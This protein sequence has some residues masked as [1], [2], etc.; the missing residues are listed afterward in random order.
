MGCNASSGAIMPSATNLEHKII[1][2][3][4]TEQTEALIN[5][6]NTYEN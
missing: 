3:V 4:V 1:I 6:L 5:F 2:L